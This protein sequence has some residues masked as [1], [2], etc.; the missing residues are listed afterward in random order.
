M[1]GKTKLVESYPE[2]GVNG[3]STSIRRP[4]DLSVSVEFNKDSGEPEITESTTLVKYVK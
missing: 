4:V 2:Y 3:S 1:E